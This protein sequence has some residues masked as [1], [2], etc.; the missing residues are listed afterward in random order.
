MEHREIERKYLIKELPEN[1]D[2][3]PFQRI[4]QAYLTVDPVIRV[5]KEGESYYITYKGSGLL[6]REEYNLPLTESAYETLSKKADGN[7]IAKKRVLIPYDRY[8][9]ELDIFDPP[10]APLILA[11]VEFES[12]EE[13]NSFAPPDWF[14]EDVTRDT[15]YHN[16][17]MS[18]K[19]FYTR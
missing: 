12:E 9:I 16:S 15:N 14:A 13:A 10:F 4:E 5:R 19:T 2:S 7:V 18:R 11:E 8:T 6:S 17:T 3:Y 1:L